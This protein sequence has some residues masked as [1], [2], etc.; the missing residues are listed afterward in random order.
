[1]PD[2]V[3]RIVEDWELPNVQT[4]NNCTIYVDFGIK[5]DEITRIV[6]VHCEFADP[7]ERYPIQTK[8]LLGVPSVLEEELIGELQDQIDDILNFVYG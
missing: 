2:P 3:E 7:L 8:P 1:M 6:K 4:F 5:D